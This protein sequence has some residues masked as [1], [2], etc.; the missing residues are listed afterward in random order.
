[1]KGADFIDQIEKDL[2]DDVDE[3][4]ASEEVETEEESLENCSGEEKAFM[5]GWK[6]AY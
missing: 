4:E 5:Q 6:Q 3:D 1:M 2:V